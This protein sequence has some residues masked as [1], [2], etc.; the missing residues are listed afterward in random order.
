[1]LSIVSQ[2]KIAAAQALNHLFPE[3][4]VTDEVITVNETK[5]EFTGDYTVVLF[6][7]VKSLRQNPAVLGK[8]LGDYLIQNNPIFTAHSTV[9]GFLNLTISDNYFA[10]FL[11]ENYSVKDFGRKESNGKKVMIEYASPN[12]NKPIHFG[13]LRN[14]FLG[15]SVSEILK[16]SGYDVIKAN[17][18]N[19][20]GIH[21]CK[22][23]IAWMRY[24][25]D[26]TPESTGIKG[27]HLV[28]DY[29]V[30]FN[31][32][33]KQEVADL[34][35]QGKEKEVAEKEAS[36]LVDAQDLLRKWEAGD[37]EVY[38]LWQTMNNWVYAGFDVTYNKLGVD[39]D[40]MYYES[41]T[42]L[43]GKEIVQEGLE[44]GILFKKEN[45]SVWIDLTADG[46]DEK[47]LLRADGTSVYMT[48]DL[49]TAR[50][51]YNDYK[52]DTSAYV[53]ADEQNYH[54]QVL[55]LIL[56]KLGE[57]CAEGIYHL[58][59]GMVE[60]PS[61]RMK[62]REGTVV[63]ADDMI[64]EM[65]RLAKEQTE[66]AGKTEGF[67]EAELEHL[68]NMVGLGALKF[69]LLRVEP[70]KKMIFDPKESIDLHGFTATFIQYAHARICSILSKND[71][72]YGPVSIGKDPLLQ[73]EKDLLLQIEQYPAIL[74]QAA[75]E[76]NP[77]SL[78]N[79]AF[80]IAQTFNS[81]YAQHSIANAES[82][83]K[84]QLRLMLATMTAN[85]LQNVMAL[86]GIEVPNK[87]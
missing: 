18:V 49:G 24:A 58:S 57:P 8:A 75:K 52:M 66:E 50:L 11:N 70:K 22:S 51:K 3:A 81:F 16:A 53:I 80:R 30:M 41:N 10:S 27:D 68:Y 14:N 63:D 69:Y 39:F 60:L 20:R 5:P 33:Y 29:Y 73:L 84:K 47:L 1:M 62:S 32:V 40:Q 15:W 44:K 85:T 38:R 76:Y 71:I 72:A 28:G 36:I 65:V 42:Y 79:Y 61:G 77:A 25:N 59:Y 2:I 87:M 78:C 17:L 4:N 34:I 23:M 55:K 45:G 19:D 86:L 21:I 83:E 6:P 12:T 64:A 46:L 67:T 13:H 31:D 7:F 9:A 26:A 43:L 74:E 54:M 48:Q 35:A 37:P 82:E 56:Q